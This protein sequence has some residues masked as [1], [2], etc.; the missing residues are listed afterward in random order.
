M[1]PNHAPPT[2]DTSVCT[3][4][5]LR[6]ALARALQVVQGVLASALDVVHGVL[7]A[8]GASGVGTT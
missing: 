4:D 5:V 8:V 1:A 7:P 3:L 6:R 2:C